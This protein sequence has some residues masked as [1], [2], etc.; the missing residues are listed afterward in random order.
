MRPRQGQTGAVAGAQQRRL[1]MAAAP[2]D[3]AGGVN[4]IAA[5]QAIGGGELGLSRLAAAQRPALGQQLRSRRAV[6]A[7]SP[8]GAKSR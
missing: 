3:G 4:H 5:G 6:D 8:S 1:V 7:A 2:P